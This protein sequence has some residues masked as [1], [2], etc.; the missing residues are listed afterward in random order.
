MP[1]KMTIL[2]IWVG[3]GLSDSILEACSTEPP[4]K[5][6]TGQVFGVYCA[7]PTPFESVSTTISSSARKDGQAQVRQWAALNSDSL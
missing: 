6:A 5:A 4:R 1:M 7:M 2:F 3:K